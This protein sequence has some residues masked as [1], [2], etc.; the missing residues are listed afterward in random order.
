MI[1]NHK[2]FEFQGKSLVE[3]LTVKSPLKQSPVFQNE[4]C[5]IYFKEGEAM[6]SSPTENVFLENGE[7]ILLKCGSYFAEIMNKVDGGVCEVFVIHL[8]PEILKDIYEDEIP[9]FLDTNKQG[10]YAQ[11]IIH[12]NV[13]QQFI[14]SLD[15]YFEN[16]Q[17]VSTE[18]LRLKLKELILLLLETNEKTAIL[19]LFAHL[20]TPR[21]ATLKEVVNAHL[22]TNITLEQMAKLA[23]HSLSTFKREFR[24][25]YENSPANYIREQRMKKAEQ[26]LKASDFSIS[27]IAYQL[28]YEDSSHFSRLFSNSYHL[29]PSEFRS[30]HRK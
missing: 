4:A 11:K 8:Y 24:I 22:F 21:K 27:E 2:H 30:N 12:K 25:H 13:I 18:L 1:L 23:G 17:L 14:Q 29:S 16:Q 19:D 3:K 6:I 7:S 15:F 20:F 5:F 28:G 9:H 10:H 26:L